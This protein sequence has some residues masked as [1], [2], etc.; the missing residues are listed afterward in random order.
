MNINKLW[1][2]DAHCDAFEMRNF[3]GHDFDLSC[4]KYLL[5]SKTKRFLLDAFGVQFST[6]AV[7]N[8]HVT[9]SRL[10]KGNVRVLFLNVSDYDLLAG[11]KMID[12]VHN[13]VNKY[14]L[15]VTICRHAKDVN[16]AIKDGKLALILVAEGPLVFQ[17]KGD[18]LRNWHRLGIQVVNLSHGEGVEGFTK[19][20]RVIYKHLLSLAPTSAWQISTSSEGF[21]SHPERSKLYKKEKGLS[22]VGKVMLKEM[23]K[24]NMICD[25][26]HAN[27]AAFWGA[28]ENTQVKVCVTHSNCASLCRHT[29]N[30]TDDMMRALANRNGVMGH[31]FYGVFID[32]HKPSLSRFV[33]HV[34]H[35][36]SIMGE[37]HV[38]IGADFD[39]VE[40]D[41]FMAIPHP[42]KMNELWE[43]LDKAGV[44]SKVMS[45]IA[46]EN[47]LRLIT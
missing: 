22:P 47:F 42:G 18:L 6:N 43:S 19:D 17:G 5:S 39:G 11:S 27:D 40:P 8:Y 29:R 2:I 44:N 45:K 1:L 34:L 41:A 4:G 38:G 31:C 23:E 10:A 33:E 7:N 15:K 30:L 16:Q 13:F 20:A 28:L 26:S 25:L 37:N 32:E 24:L 9:L 12:A 35:S 3:L 36:L 14:P 21:M 46:H